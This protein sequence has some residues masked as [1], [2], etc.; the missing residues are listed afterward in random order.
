MCFVVL[1]HG[2]ESACDKA[3]GGLND[4]ASASGTKIAARVIYTN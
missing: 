2:V 3:T 1:A 4:G